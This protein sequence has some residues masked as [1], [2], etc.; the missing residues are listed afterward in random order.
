MK[1]I[2]K[3][4]LV[5]G[6]LVLHSF[7]SCEEPIKAGTVLHINSEAQFDNL[8]LNNNVIVD[9]Y[10]S[11]CGPCK[12]LAPIFDSVAKEFDTVI[13][14][15]LDIDRFKNISNRY[16]IQSVP[17]LMCFKKSINPMLQINKVISK[18]ELK[19]CIQRCFA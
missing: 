11:W 10:A 3:S 19:K 15:K 16:R 4:C 1:F 18:T 2:A 6:L 13:F 5:L 9:F 17:T 12:I 7:T 14:I 8:V